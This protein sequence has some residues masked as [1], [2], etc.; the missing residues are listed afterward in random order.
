MGTAGG[1]LA[2][3]PELAET[4]VAGPELNVEEFMVWLVA[5]NEGL[6]LLWVVTLLLWVVAW[7]TNEAA[8]EVLTGRTGKVSA[9][10]AVGEGRKGGEVL[11]VAAAA[12]AG[13]KSPV[14]KVEEEGGAA[15][16]AAALLL[17]LLLLASRLCL[18]AECGAVVAGG[19]DVTAS[20]I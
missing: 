4:E 8:T 6:M 19:A 11:L 20:A 16:K 5:R 13:G 7:P 17:L 2:A 15:E 1:R 12:V 18:E 10:V 9:P 14:D 3:A